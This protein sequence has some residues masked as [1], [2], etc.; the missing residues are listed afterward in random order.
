MTDHYEDT[1][2]VKNRV[3]T[4]GQVMGFI[5][6]FWLRKPWLLT[7]VTVLSLVTIG[8][9]LILP[10]ASGRMVDAVATGPSEAKA[11]WAAWGL[12][13]GAGVIMAVVRNIANKWWCVLAA[14]NMAEMTDEGFAKVQSFS[15]DWHADAFAGATVRRLSRA[16]WGYDVVSDAVVMWI[17]PAL[18]VLIGLSV[19]MILRWP[20][21]GLFSLVTVL[22][23][24]GVRP[25]P[26]SAFGRVRLADRGCPGRLG[27]GQHH[28]AQFRG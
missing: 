21:V 27:Y 24:I 12:F 10:V 5:T 14:R 13:I 9:E 26:Q 7:G 23:Y 28:S 8:L 6:R 20:L 19:M 18:A 11:A 2:D 4:N 15:A 16:M 1:D 25:T 22:A 17:G 3:L